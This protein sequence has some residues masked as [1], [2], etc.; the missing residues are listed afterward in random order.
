MSSGNSNTA[1][2]T[3]QPKQEEA[4]FATLVH[5]MRAD[6]EY[7]PGDNECSTEKLGTWKNDIKSLREAKRID[8]LSGFNNALNSLIALKPR[9]DFLLDSIATTEQDQAEQEEQEQYFTFLDFKDLRNLPKPEWLLYEVLPTKGVSFVYGPAGCGK[10]Y[11]AVSMACSVATETTQWMERATKHGHVIYIAAEDIDEVAQRVIAWAD[12]HHIDDIPNLHFFPCPLKLATDTDKLIASLEH[13]YGQLD[14]ALIVVDTLAMCSIGVEE[15]SKKEFDA[16]TGSLE[17]LWRKYNCC[18]AAIHH[19]GRNGEI[20]GTSSIDGVAYSLIKVAEVDDNIMLKSVKKRRG[21]HFDDIYLDRKIVEVPGEYDEIGQ[22]VTTCVLVKSDRTAA[23][24][25]TTLTKL[26]KEILQHTSNLG[27][28]EVPR[29]DVMKAC[30]I[31]RN[32]EP[33]FC[34][35]ISVLLQK[36]LITMRTEKKR[37]FYTLTNSAK[38]LLQNV[39]V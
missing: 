33:S 17:M 10:T 22:P 23:A 29:V 2:K 12:Q 7:I 25:P 27:G 18:V 35:A 5:R 37:T 19:S 15:N 3:R 6:V 28:I 20:R 8:G 4:Q 16:V 11:V 34:N 24:D 1:T 14:I 31:D 26:Q 13:Q 32:H 38:E 39:E 21:K 36:G 9:I 30:Q